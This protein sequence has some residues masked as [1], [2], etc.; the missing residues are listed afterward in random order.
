V[1]VERL[2]VFALDRERDPQLPAD[3]A[4]VVGVSHG[5]ADVVIDDFD[6]L[7]TAATDPPPPWVG[8]ASLDASVAEVERAVCASPAAAATLA[9]VLRATAAMTV[10]D[11][12]VV[13]SLAYSTLQHGEV[14]LGWLERRG[15]PPR[16]RSA[17]GEPVRLE[18]NGD[19]LVIVLQ[20]PEVH[21]A[22]DA[23]MREALCDAFDLVALDPSIVAVQLCGDGPSFCSGGDLTEFG[24]ATDAAAAHLLR[25]DR[26]VGRRIDRCAD[27]VTARLHGACIG[28]GIELP[29]FAARVVAR[30][31]TRIRLPELSMG[32]IPG[33]GGTVSLPRRIGRHR[34]A[35]L[36]VTG[37]TLDAQTALAW[38]LVDD[39]TE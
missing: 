14:F 20:R 9:Q 36:A 15:G 5:V 29:A 28:A 33:A 11:A 23:A 21:N 26:S 3:D 17:A 37:A 38:G 32:L 19:R 10:E 4:L 18:R 22:F 2:R 1:P 13:E 6:I 12:L 27:R 8:C 31:D 25:V 39:V 34:S 7:L 30:A 16:V 35:Y 24:L